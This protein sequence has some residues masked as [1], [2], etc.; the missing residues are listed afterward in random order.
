MENQMINFHGTDVPDPGP[1]YHGTK[2]ALQIGHLLT[3]GSPS[4][5]KP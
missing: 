2:A 5:Y 1:F 4:N 3:A